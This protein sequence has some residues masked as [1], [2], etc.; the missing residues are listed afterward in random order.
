MIFGISSTDFDLEKSAFKLHTLFDLPRGRINLSWTAKEDD[1]KEVTLVIC[2]VA[3]GVLRWDLQRG[4]RSFS[5][6][7]KGDLREIRRHLREL[8]L[9]FSVQEDDYQFSV[10]RPPK[11]LKIIEI[12]E[13]P[14]EFIAQEIRSMERQVRAQFEKAARE[15]NW[16]FEDDAFPD[17]RGAREAERR[18]EA[19]RRAKENALH[20]Q[21]RKSKQE[22][23][24]FQRERQK[25]K[26]EAEAAKI[27]KVALL[28]PEIEIISDVALPPRVSLIGA[29][30]TGLPQFLIRERASSWWIANQTDELICL[31][32]CELEQHDYQIRAALRAIG[33]LRGRALLC[34]EVGLGKT[35][36][37]GLVLKELMVRGM[38]NRF[39]VITMPSLVDQWREELQHR[40]KIEAASTQELKA[41]DASF[42]KDRPG[43]VSSLH[44]LKSPQRL[45]AAEQIKWDL[46]IVDEAHHLRNSR[47]VAWGAVNRLTRQYMLLLTATPIQNGLEDLYSL[48]T[49]LKPGQ[50][51]A[52]AEFR[53]RFVDKKNPR[54]VNDAKGL[55]DLL[56]EVMIRNTRANARI[57]L[58]SRQAET[59]L[60]EADQIEKKFWSE[61]ENELR[62]NLV[63]L[64]PL[65][66][67]MRSRTLLQAAGSSPTAWRDVMTRSEDLFGSPSWLDPSI[68]ER[69]WE[70]KWRPLALLAQQPGGVV[71]FTQFR[72]TQ[73]ALTSAL[74]GE[75]AP[76]FAM[77]GSV[78]AAKR[79]D[80]VNSFRE[81]GGSLILTRSGS[82][83]RNLQFSHQIVNY[84]LPWNPM[85]IEQRIGRLHRM[86]QKHAVKI[87]NFV[88]AGS[89]QE[90]LLNLL[91]EKL[92]LFELVIG[93]TGLVLGDQYSGDE[94]SEAILEAWKI[95]ESELEKCFAQLGEELV[96]AR[97]RYQEIRETDRTL[98]D[99]DF[100]ML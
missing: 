42:W 43:I 72:L 55:R 2:A 96:A 40:F 19:A 50:L 83:G 29:A 21:I 44:T 89:L 4:K 63:K 68:P 58:P 23:R 98:F 78:P 71:I 86:G 77:D 85:E 7:S 13:E 57:D 92:N 53:R 16:F 97:S 17:P 8:A 79:T 9:H 26:Q 45:E 28:V 12:T 41:G 6:R 56:R 73:Q 70:K 67:A 20:D 34:D 64:P 24:V 60:F 87:Y 32:H 48:V 30:E 5:T 74:A 93:E 11:G 47:S 3:P 27:R 52:P 99:R 82:E 69:S 62:R 36:E 18:A 46:V 76:V 90:Q 35:I 54:K 65:Q 100:E 88:R 38:V 15:Q 80:I 49:L 81:K 1:Q 33:A 31:P 22:A 66:A 10:N 61:W 75:K 37:A 14:M 39:L 84:D 59:V 91:Q 51:P 25:A 94:F 95:G